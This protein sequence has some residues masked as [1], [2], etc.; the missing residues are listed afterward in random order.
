[1]NDRGKNVGAHPVVPRERFLMPLFA[2]DEA[3]ASR[4]SSGIDPHPFKFAGYSS[5]TSWSLPTLQNM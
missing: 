4:F 1:M 2:I 3:V 5:Q